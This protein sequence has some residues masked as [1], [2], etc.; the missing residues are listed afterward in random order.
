ML[1]LA[2]PGGSHAAAAL[3]AELGCGWHD[4]ESRRFPDAETLVCLPLPV[5]GEDLI[6]A[7]SLDRPDDKTM[8]LIFAADAARELGARSVGLVTPYLAYMR[9]D[10]RFRPGEAV[11]SRSYARLLSQ[12]L[13]WLVTVDPHLHRWNS[14]D[15]IYSIPSCVVPAAPRIAQWLRGRIAQPLLVG[16][17]EESSQWVAEVA[18]LADAPWTVMTKT[19]RGDRDVSVQPAQAGPWPGRTPVLVDDIA[20]T[21]QTLVVAA[22]ALIAAGLPAPVCVAVHALFDEHAVA[23][24]TRSG[25]SEIVSCDTVRHPS[26]GIGMVPDLAAATRTMIGRLG[27]QRA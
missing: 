21:G 4:I 18:R 7:G 14:L 19:R 6:L 1:I 22:E 9:Q 10:I 17:D 16:P 20:S 3:A 8:S 5:E 24:L 2:L 27:T 26:N 11:T 25:V 13:D 23:N 15:Q 12:R